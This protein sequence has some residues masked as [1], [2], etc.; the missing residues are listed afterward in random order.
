MKNSKDREK[1]D[2]IIKYVLELTDEEYLQRFIDEPVEKILSGFEFEREARFNHENFLNI[3]ADFVQRLY[4]KGPGIK[5][6]L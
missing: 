1:A 4:L 5:Q 3:M 6:D 2:A